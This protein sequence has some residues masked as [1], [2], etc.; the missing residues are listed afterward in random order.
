MPGVLRPDMAPG[1]TYDDIRA[2][3]DRHGPCRFTVACLDPWAD[4]NAFTYSPSFTPG[5]SGRNIVNGPGV[6]WHQLSGSKSFPFRERLKGTVRVDV[7]N[8]FKVPFF[9]FPNSAVDFRNPQR[10]GKITSTRGVTS[11]LGASKLF[12]DFQFKVEF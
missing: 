5:Q 6:L 2:P 8:P 10:F 3:F 1:K 7:N 12:I 4:L 11:G 9:G